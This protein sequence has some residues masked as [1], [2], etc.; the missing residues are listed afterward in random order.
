MDSTISRLVPIVD[1]T[2]FQ[3]SKIHS[4]S[5]T[6]IRFLELKKLPQHKLMGT[7]HQFNHGRP[8]HMRKKTPASQ[9]GKFFVKRKPNKK[10]HK[11]F[12]QFMKP[13]GHK[14]EKTKATILE[15]VS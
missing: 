9:K 1:V 15:P 11:V 12:T 2:G 10:H 14:Q 3:Q 8:K 13:P 5:V 7:E 4:S 6:K